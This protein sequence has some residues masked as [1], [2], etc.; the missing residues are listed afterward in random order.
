MKITKSLFSFLVLAAAVTTLMINGCKKDP[1]NL[2]LE[3]IAL[4]LPD[5]AIIRLFPGDTTPLKIQFTTDRPINWIKGMMDLDTTNAA[6]TP[7]Y[8]DTLF[9]VKLDTL[10]PR[11][12]RYTYTSTIR[13]ADT[14]QP[15]DILRFK[16]SFNAGKTSFTT[17]QNY[18]AGIVSASKE[19]RIDIR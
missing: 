18:P 4:V 13:V 2:P 11:V 17:G 16:I 15:F 14:L 1:E 10:E 12:N 19:F 5:T 9:F 8:P 3:P 6:Y 7:T